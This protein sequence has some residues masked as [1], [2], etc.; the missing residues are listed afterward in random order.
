MRREW[1]RRDHAGQYRGGDN[2]YE[3]DSCGEGR[4]ARLL[5]GEVAGP[6]VLG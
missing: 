2:S 3:K 1:A 4:T 5:D 6:C